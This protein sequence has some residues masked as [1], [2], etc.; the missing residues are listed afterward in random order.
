MELH[1][2]TSYL[3]HEGGTKYW[4]CTAVTVKAGADLRDHYYL[5]RDSGKIGTTFPR[6]AIK[7]TNSK[8][9][10]E[11]TQLVDSKVNR[12]YNTTPRPRGPFQD[13][14]E[15]LARLHATLARFTSE[16]NSSTVVNALEDTLTKDRIL[17]SGI[18]DTVA[19]VLPANVDP[20][21]DVD[22]VGDFA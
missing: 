4:R 19:S 20:Y 2:K 8:I 15:G 1:L 6:V 22:G 3:E 5:I 14:K 13:S 7:K 10:N 9:I 18:V 17:T 21:K 12:G 16:D 11:L